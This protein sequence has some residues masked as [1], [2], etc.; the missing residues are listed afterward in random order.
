LLLWVPPFL[1]NKKSWPP[2]NLP[3]IHLCSHLLLLIKSTKCP[4]PSRQANRNSPK[5]KEKVIKYLD[6]VVRMYLDEINVWFNKPSRA[7]K[8]KMLDP[9]SFYVIAWP[10]TSIFCLQYQTETSVLFGLR[11]TSHWLS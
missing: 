11:S 6:V 10:G 2:P 7:D 5:R 9:P 8:T 1:S 3:F 4:K